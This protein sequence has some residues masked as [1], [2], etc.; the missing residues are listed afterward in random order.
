MS[1]EGQGCRGARLSLRPRG[2][3]QDWQ[4][5]LQLLVWLRIGEG[6]QGKF[7]PDLQPGNEPFSPFWFHHSTPQRVKVAFT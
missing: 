1:P 7:K 3:R 2:A 5:G 6:T 4:V